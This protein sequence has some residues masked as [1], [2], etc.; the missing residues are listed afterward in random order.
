MAVHP[1]RGT[2]HK[3]PHKQLIKLN[4]YVDLH[5]LRITKRR[6]PLSHQDIIE[7]LPLSH[8][9]MTKLQPLFSI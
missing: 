2:I 6:L 3:V 7:K 1:C 8:Q 9:D 5:P 4:V